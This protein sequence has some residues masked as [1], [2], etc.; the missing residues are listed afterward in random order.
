MNYKNL[1][2]WVPMLMLVFS[3]CG[4]KDDAEH[5]S[6]TVVSAV[7]VEGTESKTSAVTTIGTATSM[8]GTKVSTTPVV[9]TGVVSTKVPCEYG[10]LNIDLDGVDGLPEES[11][12]LKLSDGAEAIHFFRAQQLLDS[13]KVAKIYYK[14]LKNKNFLL[15]DYIVDS[16]V[17]AKK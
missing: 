6:G 12:G 16:V 4:H 17:V 15:K 11:I 5:K 14:K 9:G 8:S 1:R 2:Y 3:G 13:G 10:M 7:V